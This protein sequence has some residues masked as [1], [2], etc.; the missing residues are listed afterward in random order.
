MTTPPNSSEQTWESELARLEADV[1]AAEALLA[2]H[3]SASLTETADPV[4]PDNWTPPTG[5]GALPEHLLPRARAVLERQQDVAE[6]LRVAQGATTRQ[7]DFAARVTDATATRATPAYL[8]VN[9]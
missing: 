5:L 9:A 7:R 1:A 2:D 4:A 8:D 3:T 6:R